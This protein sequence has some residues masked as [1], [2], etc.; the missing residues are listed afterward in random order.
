MNAKSAGFSLIEIVIAIAIFAFGLI[1]IFNMFIRGT[2]EIDYGKRQTRATILAQDKMEGLKALPFYASGDSIYVDPALTA[3]TYSDTVAIDDQT[4]ID[5]YAT[6]YWTITDEKYAEE[7]NTIIVKGL[8][9]WIEWRGRNGDR[10][11]R[12]ESTKRRQ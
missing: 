6:R 2:T 9:V 5:R 11:Y 8:T 1:A 12:I 3:G 4:V 10:T 7:D